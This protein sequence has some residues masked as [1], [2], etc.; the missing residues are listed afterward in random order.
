M[1]S[2]TEAV[3]RLWEYLEDEVSAKERDAVEEHLAFCRR[4]C[5]EVEFADELRAVLASAGEVTLPHEVESRLIGVLDTLPSDARAGTRDGGR[6]RPR[7][8]GRT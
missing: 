5:G 8:R 6:W 7:G 2:C 3:R 4:C 1:I